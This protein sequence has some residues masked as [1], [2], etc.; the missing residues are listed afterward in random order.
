MNGED[1]P[2]VAHEVVEFEEEPVEVRDFK[3]MN[4]DRFGGIHKICQANL[5][6]KK[7]KKKK[8]KM[9]TLNRLDLEALDID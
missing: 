5:I 6:K 1:R 4:P 2:L 7:K 3:K 9:S 8:L